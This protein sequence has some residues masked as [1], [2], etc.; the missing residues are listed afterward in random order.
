M[1]APR[2]GA[3]ARFAPQ[4]ERIDPARVIA[5]L[6]E[7]RALTAGAGGAD[8]VA[9]SEG[10]RTARAML[11]GRLEALGIPWERDEAGN[12]WATV[13][14]TRRG[15]VAIGSHLDAVPSGGWLDGALGVLTAL[16]LMRL[17]RGAADPPQHTVALVDFADEE[18]ARFG[19]S[20]FGSSAV[21][22]ALDPRELR[23]LCNGDGESLSALLRE[24]GVEVDRIGEAAAR[25]RDLVAYLELHIEQGPVLEGLGLS[26]A[27][28]RAVC[29]IERY[30]V[31]I[32]GETGHAGAL[33][34]AARCD[35]FL[36][37]ADG[38][39]R[40]EAVA[41]EHDGMA[42][43]GQIELAPGI[44]TAVAGAA[45]FVVDLRHP[46]PLALA[47]FAAAVERALSAAAAQ[48]GC[49]CELSTIWRMPPTRFDPGLVDAALAI[50]AARTGSDHLAV[51]GPGHDAVEMARHVATVMLF[52]PSTGGVSHSP[53]E[54][55]P[56]ADLE[57]AIG[58]FAVLALAVV[59]GAV[60]P[61]PDAAVR[62]G[63]R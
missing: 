30:R 21:S 34:M 52:A 38:A 25:R 13:A 43:I 57:V 53:L 17:I 3:T 46:E 58:A 29:G 41:R 23:D 9:W 6:R 37:A 16:E 45:S 61:M 5:D 10:W 62:C 11:T 8:R 54:D 7:L 59:E 51:S 19:R 2:P 42:T 28:V 39:L 47:P 14:G 48:R 4:V 36:A 35:A 26:V 27:P 22:G 44:A 40:M 63:D 60:A 56:V 20:L 1:G 18:G 12:I 32:T 50:C 31:T 24:N 55:T 15:T 33:P 49:R